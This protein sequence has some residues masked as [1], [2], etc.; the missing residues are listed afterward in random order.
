MFKEV[1]FLADTSLTARQ[2]IL[3]I[4][5]RLAEY[6]SRLYF[7]QFAE[8]VHPFFMDLYY[9]FRK[10]VLPIELSSEV[11]D[12]LYEIFKQAEDV[13]E[14]LFNRYAIGIFVGLLLRPEE[15]T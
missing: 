1:F 5:G 4:V 11:V 3:I 8:A 15:G 2:Y 6:K 14:L 9:M 12:L 13:Y 7:E 10:G